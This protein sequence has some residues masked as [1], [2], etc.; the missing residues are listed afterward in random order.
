MKRIEYLDLSANRIL[1]AGDIH[2][3]L[4]ALKRIIEIFNPDEDHL[5]F[6]G[7]YA[8]RGENGVECIEMIWD[9]M[10][11]YPESVTALKGNHEDFDGDGNPLFMPC[12]LI[13]EVE[14]KRGNWT[15]YFKSMKNFLKLLKIGIIFD[16]IIFVHGFISSGIESMDRIDRNI[17]IEII[18]NDPINEF[19]EYSN[20]RGIGKLVGKDITS[21]FLEKFGINFI[22]RSHEPRKALFAP[23]IEQDG[24]AL[25]ISSTGVYGGVPHLLVI[26]RDE[27]PKNG[28]SASKNFILL[29]Q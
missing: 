25:T 12:D 3:D 13:Y 22:I 1:V 6:L 10:L 2:G 17:E 9:L 18:W 16:K 5:I 23:F 28:V 4:V 8:D 7:D 15:N 29:Y 11:K 21:K 14:E 20:P 24:L 27:I 26:K 19:G